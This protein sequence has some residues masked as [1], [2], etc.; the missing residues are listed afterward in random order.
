MYWLK[1]VPFKAEAITHSAQDDSFHHNATYDAFGGD[2]FCGWGGGI[3]MRGLCGRL[4]G[5]NS[6]FEEDHLRMLRGVRLPAP[7]RI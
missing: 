5:R 4:D 7:V 1:P 2:G 3:W 6:V